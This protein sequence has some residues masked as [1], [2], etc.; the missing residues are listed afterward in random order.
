MYTSCT[1]MTSRWEESHMYTSCTYTT[2]RW[3]ESH[4]YTSCTYTTS[5]WE[6]SHMYTSCT[7]TTSRWEESH[8]YTS[9]TYTTSRW[10]ESG[11]Y[12]KVCQLLVQSGRRLT[13]RWW[14]TLTGPSLRQRRH[15][16]LVIPGMCVCVEVV[17]EAVHTGQEFLFVP[18]GSTCMTQLFQHLSSP[19][20]N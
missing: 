6:E 17:R 7:Y 15:S 1:Y 20:P 5:R 9:C 8:M 13:Y 18:S 12:L 3:E 14:D 2:S 11:H 16:R 4:M 19:P 10:E